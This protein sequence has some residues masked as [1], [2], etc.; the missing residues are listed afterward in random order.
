MQA[1]DLSIIL[2]DAKKGW[3]AVNEKNEIVVTAASFNSLCKKVEKIKEELTLIP[4]SHD[5]SGLV[6]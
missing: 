6:T 2:K 3:V 5:Y 4:A 1:R